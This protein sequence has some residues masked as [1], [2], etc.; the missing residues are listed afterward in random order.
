MVLRREAWSWEAWGGGGL[1]DGRFL[2]RPAGNTEVPWNESLCLAEGDHGRLPGGG[3]EMLGAQEHTLGSMCLVTG[4]RIRPGPRVWREGMWQVSQGPLLGNL[5][6]IRQV[7][8]VLE[9]M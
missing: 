8:E 3:G 2:T 9:I 1:A 7:L 4:R 6:A 5:G